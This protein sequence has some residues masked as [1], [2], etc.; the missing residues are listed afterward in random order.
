MEVLG[1]GIEIKCI[2]FEYWIYELILEGF[3]NQ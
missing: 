3:L 1:K 2:C